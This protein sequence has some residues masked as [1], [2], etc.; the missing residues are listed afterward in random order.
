[1]TK[2]SRNIYFCLDK[3]KHIHPRHWMDNT[4][5]IDVLGKHIT[6][7]CTCINK[8]ADNKKNVPISKLLKGL[9]DKCEIYEH[10]RIITKRNKESGK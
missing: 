2:D 8:Y 6:I 1:M 7:C 3:K 10:S 9:S 5:G 4:V